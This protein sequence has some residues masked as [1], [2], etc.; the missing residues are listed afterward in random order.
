MDVAFIFLQGYNTAHNENNDEWL[1][2]SL[3]PD[4]IIRYGLSQC[5]AYLERVAGC[6]EEFSAG[7]SEYPVEFVYD[8]DNVVTEYPNAV[9]LQV[10][11][12]VKGEESPRVSE[13]H[14]LV[15]QFNEFWYANWFTD[16]GDPV[17]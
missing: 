8:K 16:C 3:H 2:G 10:E 1:L 7:D 9:R 13:M 6:C 15:N 14:I 4:S 12:T 11:F 17:Q 5:Q